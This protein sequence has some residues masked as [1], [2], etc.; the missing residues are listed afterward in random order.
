MYKKYILLEQQTN[1]T[2]TLRQGFPTRELHV[3]RETILCGP[4]GQMLQNIFAELMT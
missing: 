2:F 1:N 4:Q 3:A